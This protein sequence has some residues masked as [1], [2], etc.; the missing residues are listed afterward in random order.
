MRGAVHHIDLTVID[1]AARITVRSETPD[2]TNAADGAPRRGGGAKFA[3]LQMSGP[4]QTAACLMPIDFKYLDFL[5]ETTTRTNAF[6]FDYR[7]ADGYGVSFY[8]CYFA[9]PD[10][11]TVSS[12][13][14]IAAVQNRLGTV[15]Q[16]RFYRCRNAVK[17]S[18]SGIGC[19]DA[20][21]NN[22]RR[23]DNTIIRT[24]IDDNVIKGCNG[25][26]ISVNGTKNDI[27]DN[28][29]SDFEVLGTSHQDCIQHT[30]FGEN[31]TTLADVIRMRRNVFNRGAGNLTKSEPQGYFVTDNDPPTALAGVE[32]VNNVFVGSMPNMTVLQ[33]ATGPLVERN[34]ILVAGDYPDG[35]TPY[36][37][38]C[39]IKQGTGG[40]LDRCYYNDIDVS[41]QPGIVST[42]NAEPTYAEYPDHF[43]NPV[44][45]PFAT[46]AEVIAAWKAKAGGSALLGDGTYRGA[47]FPD[48]TWNDGTVY[49]A[50]PP[51]TI[52][53]EANLATVTVNQSVTITYQLDAAANQVVTVTPGV[54]GVTGTFSAATA[55]IGVGSASAQITFTPTS[56]GT[57]TLS[58][59]DDRSLTGPSNITVTVTAAE[60]S[61]P[62]S[63]TQSADRSS[64]TLGGGVI[65][66]YTLNAVATSPV[67][68]TPAVSGVTGAFS[69]ATVTI[70][71]GAQST[72]V[73]F[74]PATT[75]TASLAASDDASLT[76]P[77]AIQVEV[78]AVTKGQLITLGL[79]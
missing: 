6:F 77:A 45:G 21:I 5:C 1:L 76:D 71:A 56:V 25:D 55:T 16:C 69:Q 73:S 4:A 23:V 50:T 78:S 61:A 8:E 63:Y 30:G 39:N 42:N 19:W 58:A 79:A 70:G 28:F 41:L 46:K 26:A 17:R 59:A 57:A 24:L 65:I 7:S 11:V 40:V 66:T 47:L 72:T 74:F 35:S 52:T 51:T 38:T 29:G 62:T 44:Y 12:T 34:T 67:V 9:V 36:N 60:S 27:F 3:S 18:G 2:A 64:V 15:K 75:G 68:I 13:N 32:L 20:S 43:V 10:G 37:G 31:G 22:Y 53:Q 14:R 48:G 33:A 54:S 49:Q